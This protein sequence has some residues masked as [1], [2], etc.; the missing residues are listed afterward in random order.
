MSEKP[1]A[2]RQVHFENFDELLQ[3]VEMLH[4]AASLRTGGRWTA[5]QNIDHVRRF[6]TMSR[7][8]T[9]A[10]APLWL[11]ILGRL[12]RGGLGKRDVPSGLKIPPSLAAEFVPP[13]DITMDDVVEKFRTEV[14]LAKVPGSMTQSSPVFG[15]LDHDKWY[16]LHLRHAE[17]HMGFIAPE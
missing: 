12:L 7:E 5:A 9:T 15:K 6:I 1:K 8:G 13:A 3:D 10:K 4:A 11:R 14:A 17:L 16:A 2:L